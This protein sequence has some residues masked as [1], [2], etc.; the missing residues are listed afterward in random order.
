M[1]GEMT[2]NKSPEKNS[3]HILFAD[4]EQDLQQIIG[5]KLKKMGH[6]VVVC[7]DGLTAVAALEKEPFDCPVS[8]THLTLP[9]IYS[10]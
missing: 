3:M 5:S 2:Q 8:Y 4:D 7:P 6:S 1:D 9:T 10:V